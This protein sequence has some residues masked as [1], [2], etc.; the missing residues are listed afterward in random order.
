MKKYTQLQIPK[1]SAWDRKTWRSY[2]PIWFNRFIEGIRNIIIWIPIIYKNKNW[3][4]RYIYDIFEFK[5]LQQRNYLVKANRHSSIEETNRYIT[6]CLNLI[7]RIKD[8]YYSCEYLEYHEIYHEFVP[9]EGREEL[10][11]LETTMIWEKYN[12]YLS[13]YPLQVKKLLKKDP[14]L[15][16]D[17]H[18][19][20]MFVGRE[21]GQRAQL[22]LFKIMDEKIKHWWD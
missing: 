6:V 12:A 5:L 7:Q 17:E 1:D 13:M 21:N 18:K 22:L 9:I 16:E 2:T 10:Y 8:D 15:G 20:C 4:W 14:E 3:D 11:S 19:L